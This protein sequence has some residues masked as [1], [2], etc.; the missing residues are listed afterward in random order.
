MCKRHVFLHIYPS[1]LLITAVFLP[2]LHTAHVLCWNGE[3]KVRKNRLL[4]HQIKAN[5][6]S[7]TWEVLSS[8]LSPI[9]CQ[10]D[11][12]NYN[13]LSFP[14]GELGIFY[15]DRVTTLNVH[16][17]STYGMEFANASFTGQGPLCLWW[18]FRQWTI[19][20]DLASVA[21]GCRERPIR[22]VWLRFLSSNF[23]QI[24]GLLP[25][26]KAPFLNQWEE[27]SI[28]KGK[29]F[30]VWNMAGGVWN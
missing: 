10:E 18:S 6:C 20:W 16:Q 15:L 1:L 2:L 29:L 27:I 4:F 13:E 21:L 11:N 3:T 19:D 28:S 25:Q 17:D 22:S 12:K 8:F 7:V 24:K 9:L 5:P 30:H 14:K 23:C 26:S